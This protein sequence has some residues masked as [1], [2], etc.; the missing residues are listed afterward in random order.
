MRLDGIDPRTTISASDREAQLRPTSTR[1][2]GGGS[3]LP[4]FLLTGL[5]ACGFFGLVVF[6]TPTTRQ[7]AETGTT[8][9][10][11]ETGLLIA[12]SD[13]TSVAPLTEAG[14]NTEPPPM[15]VAGSVS[16]APPAET[17]L[18]TIGAA[19]QPVLVYD[20]SAPTTA[21]RSEPAA[22]ST[23]DARITNANAL[24]ALKM[25]GDKVA[26]ATQIGDQARLILQGTMIPATLETAINSELPG[27]TRAV[28]SADVRSADGTQVLI[29]RGSRLIGQYK[30]AL[31]TGESRAFVVWDRLL[32]PDGVSVSLT[33][34]T[35]DT[36]GQE[37]ISGKVHNHYGARYGAAVM[38]TVLNGLVG[39]LAD[40]DSSSTTIVVTTSGSSTST[41]GT[42][43][44]SSISPTVN[45]KAGV[46]VQVFLARDLN[47]DLNGL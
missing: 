22:T 10:L 17:V 14:P 20:S 3:R 16:L 9:V 34:P 27:Y 35:T 8:E 6:T 43:V 38:L 32:R 25:G 41:N 2:G 30:S 36:I 11:P 1:N 19:H 23:M 28:V 26:K 29:P 46:Q 5:A 40:N 18:A 4:F 7:A 37:G 31:S 15:V 13:P 42:S 44:V 24:F 33:S 47:F 45:V 21:P 12:G 39:S